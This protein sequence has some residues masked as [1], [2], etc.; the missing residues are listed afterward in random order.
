[1]ANDSLQKRVRDQFSYRGSRA[2]IWTVF[3]TVLDTQAFLNLGYSPWHLPHFVGSS[4]RRLTRKVGSEL[5][6][7]LAVPDGGRLLDVGCGRGGPAIYFAD[8]LGFDVTGVDLVPYNVAVA[9]DNT[10]VHDVPA[11]FIVGD[12]THL[13]V[14]P[15]SFRVCTALDS[16]VCVPEKQAAFDEMATVLQD[17]GLL[18]LSDLVRCEGLSETEITVV[19]EF[20]DAWDM[21]PLVPREQYRRTINRAGFVGVELHDISP[22]SVTRL[23]KWTALYL[24]LL[25]TGAGNAAARLARRR[26]L[27]TETTTEQ[28]RSAHEALP[29][30]RHVNIYAR[31]R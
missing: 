1:M 16:I 2:D 11:A 3:D 19:D 22:H 6:A 26:G 10:V 15:D 29:Y 13:P 8:A 14:K 28:I 17:G 27:D 9:R 23:R 31:K 5:T 30:L 18:A 4:Q 20:A 12:A 7:R 24:R 21:P 25:D